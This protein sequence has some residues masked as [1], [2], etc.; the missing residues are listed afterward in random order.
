[1]GLE[2]HLES[3]HPP[4]SSCVFSWTPQL[5][6]STDATTESKKRTAVI[7]FEGKFDRQSLVIAHKLL[8]TIIVACRTCLMPGTVKNDLNTASNILMQWRSRKGRG[9]RSVS[10]YR[11][12][13]I[14]KRAG[15]SLA[16]QVHP[17]TGHLCGAG[18]SSFTAQRHSTQFHPAIGPPTLLPVNRNMLH[19]M[20]L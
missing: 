2:C 6:P 5:C 4:P 19:S 1:M 18:Y 7:Y 13:P 20:T 9:D 16:Q 17:F 15:S 12:R 11:N 14:A 8:A 3:A 10:L